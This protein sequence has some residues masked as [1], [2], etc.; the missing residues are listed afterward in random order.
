M[1]IY[2]LPSNSNR[3]D[4]QI[5]KESDLLKLH[6]HNNPDQI[7]FINYTY[8]YC[9]CIIDIVNSTLVIKELTNSEKNYDITLYF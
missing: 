9:I 5:I 7:T 2:S 8:S 3:F 6:D 1:S 4:N